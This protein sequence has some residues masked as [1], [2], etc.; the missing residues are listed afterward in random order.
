MFHAIEKY[1]TPARILLGL[2]AVTF[3]GFGASTLAQPGHDYAL[4]IGDIKISEN[5]INEALRRVQA[6]GGA[7]DRQAVVQ[8]LMQQAYLQ[9]GGLDLGATASLEQIKQIIA[10]DPEFQ[11]N[12][13]FS[14]AKYQAFL[15]NSQLTETMLIEDMR[16]QFAIQSVINLLQNG[17]V[18]ADAQ[19]Q[20]I[21]NPLLAVRTIRAA[22][23]NPQQYADQVKADAAALKS[24]YEAN[25]ERYRQEEAVKFEFVVLSAE[26]L[27]QKAEVSEADIQQAYAQLPADASAAKPALDQVR[28]QLINDIRLRKGQQA[29]A[30]SRES[31][32]DW[33][34]NH[35]NELASAAK[36]FGLK[37]EQHEQWLTRAE[38]QAQGMPAE[39]QQALFSPEVLKQ[40][41]NSEPVAIG[42]QSIW[43]V[44]ATAVREAHLAKL[45]EVTDQVR[46][47]YVGE[48]SRKLA[49]T[50][51]DAAYKQVQ[52]GKTDGITWLPPAQATAEQART[53]MAPADFRKLLQAQPKDGKPAYFVMSEGKMPVLMEVQSIAAPAADPNLLPQIKQLL[54]QQQ[55]EVFFSAYLRHMQQRYP[56]K[57][58]AQQAVADPE[59]ASQ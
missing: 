42:N 10:T 59:A 3:I 54:T 50:A 25:K 4:K 11:D 8:A 33:V 56:V 5:D 6:S 27:G 16:K 53:S 30:A 49:Q 34:F 14:E 26:Q 35:P 29:L 48:E 18:V 1:K 17:V 46:Q 7:A 24:Y 47:D 51:A 41:H 21:M 23:F 45:D 52:A 44:R 20:Q 12:G 15:R 37:L 13:R 40:K 57:Q 19:A 22:E 39:L 2:I 32:A 36:Q 43:V 31:L 38:A 55:Q 28:A 58:G 9:Q